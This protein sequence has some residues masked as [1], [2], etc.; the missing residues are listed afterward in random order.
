MKKVIFLIFAASFILSGCNS[1]KT[2]TQ[3][4]EKVQV[5][6]FGEVFIYMPVY[7][8]ESK[9]FFKEE[10]LE[11][12]LTS[13]GGDDKTFAALISGSATFGIADPT[14][15]AIATEKGQG[16]KVIASVV[17]GVPFWGVAKKDG[18]V[19]QIEKAEQLKG[20]SV[21]TFPSPSTAFSLQ[22]KM[23][24]DAGLEPNIRQ[25]ALGAL[26]PLLENGNADI[27]LEL[28]PNVSTAIKNNNCKVV[29]SLADVYGDFAITGV[30]VLEST[31]K[32]K[33]EL[34]QKFVNALQKAETFA[35]TYPDS[36]VYYATKKFP[37]M[38]K[39]IVKDAM[40][41][42]IESNTLPKS[43]VISDEA[44]TKAIELRKEIGDL[45]SIE[46]AKSV[47]DMSFA[48]KLQ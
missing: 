43:V 19:P 41:R 36:A 22:T 34:V 2:K 39:G 20:F 42:I 28:E 46:I 31:I 24:K 8:A 29:Y 32:S 7:L 9:G 17:N 4:L 45:N 47:L 33:P 30:T 23:F 27:A 3:S 15:A 48:K 10:G 25:A 21:A 6:Q 38:D 35:H 13:T 11:I 14:F 26:L 44:W 18:K 12:S 5:A 40:Y 37:D 1:C 16:G